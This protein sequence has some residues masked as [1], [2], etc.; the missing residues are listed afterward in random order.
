[1]RIKK[2]VKLRGLLPQTVLASVVAAGVYQEHNQEFRLTS[3]TEGMHMAGSL[4]FSG[5]AFDCGIR[6]IG[7][8]EAKKIRD[9]ISSRLQG[10]FDVV[11]EKNHIHVEYQP[12]SA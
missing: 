10:E 4:H 9:E 5:G 1:M 11:L 3:G 8:V 2:G 7:S 12:K 6:G